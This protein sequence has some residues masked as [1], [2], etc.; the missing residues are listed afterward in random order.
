MKKQKNATRVIAVVLILLMALALLPVSASANEPE[1]LTWYLV[2]NGGKTT[3]DE[4]IVEIQVT[5]GNDKVPANPFTYKDHTFVGWDTSGN[6]EVNWDTPGVDIA[7]A[8]DGLYLH[9]VWV[10]DPMVTF[11][12]NNQLATYQEMKVRF[13]YDSSTNIEDISIQFKCPIYTLMGWAKSDTGPKEIDTDAYLKLT[14]DLELYAVWGNTVTYA[15]NG[16]SGTAAPVTVADGESVTLP[17]PGTRQGFVFTGWQVGETDTILDADETTFTPESDVTLTA[18]WGEDLVAISYAGNGGSGSTAGSTV[19]RGD[20]YAIQPNGFTAPSDSQAFSCWVDEEHGNTEY[21][22]GG[23]P[24]LLD[25]STIPDDDDSVELTAQWVHLWK[26]TFNT[27]GVSVSGYPHDV[28]VPAGSTVGSQLAGGA[29]PTPTSS[30]Y[31]FV[32]WNE[33]ADGSGSAYT[34]GFAPVSDKVFWAKWV[35]KSVTLKYA[36]GGGS[37]T[38]PDDTATRNAAFTL[39]DCGFTAPSGKVFKEWEIDGTPIAAGGSFTPDLDTPNEVT[40]TAVWADKLAGTVAFTKDG[41]AVAADT[42]FV[43]DD[44]LTATLTVTK[45]DP[46]PAQIRYQ[47][48]RGENVVASG[49]AAVSGGE[50]D[51]VYTVAADDLNKTLTFRFTDAANFEDETRVVSAAQKIK[52]GS[53]EMATLTF[54]ATGGT[55]A[56]SVMVDDETLSFSSGTATC[57]VFKG[58][59][60]SVKF[61][62][63]DGRTFDTVKLDG[64]DQEAQTSYSWEI[65]DDTAVAVTF[66]ASSGE[67][68]TA[69][70]D[71]SAASDANVLKLK[72]ALM[73]MA[74]KNPYASSEVVVC[75]DGDVTKKADPK[76][77]SEGGNVPDAGLEFTLPYPKGTDVNTTVAAKM[78]SYYTVKVYHWNGTAAVEVTSGVAAQDAFADGVKVTSADFSPYGMILTA[79]PLS[80]TVEIQKDGSKVTSASVGETLTAKYTDGTPAHQGT[81]SYQWQYDDGTAISGA[82]AS[83]YK[84]TASD[85]GKKLQCVVTSSFESGSLTSTNKV[86]ISGKPSPKVKQDII[87]DGSEQLGK[88]SNVTSEMEYRLSSD[89]SWKS[90][91]SGKTEITGLTRAGTYY[92]RFKGDTSSANWGKVEIKSYYTVTCYPDSVSANRL[93]FSAAGSYAYPYKKNVWLVENGKTINVTASSVNTKYYRI[94]GITRQMVYEPHTKTSKSFTNASSG[95]T[96]SFTVKNT[97]YVI[98]ASAGVYGSKTG[99]SSHLGLW[100]ELA[101]LSLMGLCAAAVFGRRKFRKQ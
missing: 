94:T 84:P 68:V 9:A 32:E 58:A 79:V 5:A 53:A 54:T 1:T 78:K 13:L 92:V 95:S 90:V 44:E 69:V 6:G 15:M 64:V 45:P 24:V 38:M 74:G 97:P 4:E 60:V 57:D 52:P 93:A 26:I 70:V 36:S 67:E 100:M 20:D 77:V 34:A 87:N 62:P 66:K 98:W 3:D 28:D 21:T 50:A 91:G 75:W 76:K 73:A 10:T 37:G 12:G 86:T 48:V 71:P 65:A 30:D 18:Q 83:T 51:A 85:I 72:N 47:V 8:T 63:G 96:S 29:L 40:V 39:P 82:T 33:K 7:P 41:A 23:T 99:D 61:V 17:D 49:T 2:G 88:I 59:T 81:L 16:G 14:E 101:C 35:S 80:G 42:T 89:P 27:N 25:W 55:A 31:S 22:P 43:T 19:Q 11:Y 56:D 46:A